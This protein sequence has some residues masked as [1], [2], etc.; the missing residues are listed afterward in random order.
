MSAS[1]STKGAPPLVSGMD[2]TIP[3]LDV[4]LPGVD[5]VAVVVEDLQDGVERYRAILGVEPWH[6]HRFEPPALTDT[7]YR[8]EATEYGMWLA[9]ADAGDTQ[10]E[11][12]EPTMGPNIYADHLDEHGEGL[13]HVAYFGWDA[14]ETEAVVASF[15]ERGMPIVQ[16]GTIEGTEFVYLDT[17]DELNG[18]LFETALRRTGGELEPAAVYPGDPFPE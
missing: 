11:L 18:L 12:I 14:A 2:P 13:H 7:T 6:V 9:L 16:R 3:D 15:E 17:A 1:E 5:Q 10:V 8:G 4:E